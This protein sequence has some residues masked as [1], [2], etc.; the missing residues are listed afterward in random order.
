MQRIELIH[1]ML[2]RFTPTASY[3]AWLLPLGT[4]GLMGGIV[5]GRSMGRMLPV[6]AALGFAVLAAVISRKCQRTWQW[7]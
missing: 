3:H 6:C 4:L 7:R 5:L 1:I 2:R